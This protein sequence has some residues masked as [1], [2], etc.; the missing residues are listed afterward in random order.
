MA[1]VVVC[2]SNVR[3]LKTYIISIEFLLLRTNPGRVLYSIKEVEETDD[4]FGVLNYLE[5][6]LF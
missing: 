2:Y 6:C 3:V 1:H 4:S 5:G